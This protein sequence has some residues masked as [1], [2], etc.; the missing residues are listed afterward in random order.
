MGGIVKMITGGGQSAPAP[1]PTAPTTSNSS[2]AM[3]A[4]AADQQ[5]AALA[6]RSSTMLTGGTGVQNMGDTTSKK[7]LG[8]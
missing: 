6:G 7:L 3:D 8:S 2:A 4:A 5:R 1:V